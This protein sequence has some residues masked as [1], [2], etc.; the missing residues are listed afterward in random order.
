[1]PPAGRGRGG[2]ARGARGRGGASTRGGRASA[3]TEGAQNTDA[4]TAE[5]TTQDGGSQAN[6]P[7]ASAAVPNSQTNPTQPP[8]TTT[9]RP[10]V[11]AARGS[12]SAGFAG[13]GRFLPKGV[14]RAQAE[15]DQ[16]A[17]Q[18]LR[19]QEDKA[20]L[21]ARIKARAN[22]ARGRRA[23]GGRGGTFP[24]R[25]IRGGTGIGAFSSE[26]GLDYGGSKPKVFAGG[27]GG[28]SGSG[29]GGGRGRG[30]KS[31]KG[32]DLFYSSN[33]RNSGPRVNADDLAPTI[34]LT[35]VKDEEEVGR[36]RAVMPMGMV[37]HEHKDPEVVVATSA[38]LE[39][40]EQA[41]S[42]E[43]SSS[44]DLIMTD[45][46]DYKIVDDEKVWPGAPQKRR[47]KVEDENGEQIEIT[48][49]DELAARRSAV[50]PPSSPE[51]KKKVAILENTEIK[52][53][54]PRRAAP[55]DPEDEEAEDDLSYILRLFGITQP[56]GVDMSDIPVEERVPPVSQAGNMYLFQL[57]PVLPPLAAH[58]E[59]KS[60]NPV[61]DEPND[62]VV[63]LDAPVKGSGGTVD[64]TSEDQTAIKIEDSIEPETASKGKIP[65]DAELYGKG[66]FVGK[67][68]VRK[69]GK[70]ELV[71][72]GKTLEV[73]PGNPVSFQTSAIITEKDDTKPQPGEKAG[74]SYGMGDIKGKFV[75]APVWAEEEE[76]IV[77][78]SELPPNGIDA[79]S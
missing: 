44:E 58:S 67:L 71:W 40:A 39:A 70:I 46:T 66:G 78:A 9:T 61:K 72:G 4:T 51:Q 45:A 55:K 75:V 64:L 8:T 57:P 59:P 30:V 36:K 79:A 32:Q 35:D 33:S 34:D 65:S 56:E 20:A 21:D 49:I 23:R 31:E 26:R 16:L 52:P 2:R 37:R 62:D 12:S 43:T 5:T 24:D 10:L 17:Q 14:R 41:M 22:R 47:I 1:M 38:E 18:E 15:R 29:A 27:S 48:E 54:R 50:K 74:H 69:S 60:T 28:G 3:A 77:D 19:K 7:E 6:A 76:W 13:V 73:S 68:N 42:G 63:M 25:I 11:P 53:P